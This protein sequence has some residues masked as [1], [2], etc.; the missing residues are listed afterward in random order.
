MSS[1]I[2]IVF[3]GLN[4]NFSRNRFVSPDGL[5]DTTFPV[6]LGAQHTKFINS[7]ELCNCS[8]SLSLANFDAMNDDTML[9]NLIIE[10]TPE[11]L[12]D[13]NS[14]VIPRIVLFKTQDGRKGAIKIKDYISNGTNS[15]IIVD[16]KVQKESR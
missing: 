7:Q 9:Q 6:I 3:F 8:D 2:D 16:I 14:D 1:S 11:G 5:M 15:Y 12:Q 10:E 13:F 4:E